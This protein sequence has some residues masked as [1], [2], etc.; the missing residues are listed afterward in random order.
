[1][2]I[3][4]EILNEDGSSSSGKILLTEEFLAQFKS[5]KEA[6]QYVLDKGMYTLNDKAGT[7]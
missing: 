1:M 6:V 3:D 2:E 7:N 5:N 4:I